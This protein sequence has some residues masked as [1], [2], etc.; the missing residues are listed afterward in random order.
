ML[1]EDWK[2]NQPTNIPID[3]FIRY[4][5]VNPKNQLCYHCTSFICVMFPHFS[6]RIRPTHHSGSRHITIVHKTITMHRVG[7]I[8]VHN[9]SISIYKINGAIK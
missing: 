9:I 3:R 6:E 1:F 7:K 2:L 4:A 5:I 8:T